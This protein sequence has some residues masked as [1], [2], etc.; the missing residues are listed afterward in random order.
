MNQGVSVTLFSQ[1]NCINKNNFKTC[2]EIS[3]VNCGNESTCYKNSSISIVF[4]K[5]IINMY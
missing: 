2:S 4:I 1:I 3:A 5:Q